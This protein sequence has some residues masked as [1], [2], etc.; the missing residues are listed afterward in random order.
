MLVYGEKVFFIKG[1]EEKVLEMLA[2]APQAPLKPGRRGWLLFYLGVCSGLAGGPSPWECGG[3]GADR[4][5]GALALP[6]WTRLVPSPLCP[7]LSL[8]SEEWRSGAPRTRPWLCC[9]WRSSHLA[10]GEPGR[11]CTLLPSP[12]SGSASP[13]ALGDHCVRP[14]AAFCWHSAGAHCLPEVPFSMG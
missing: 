5:E 13:R 9:G 2:E 11:R 6:H 10:L 7:G 3:R 8:S 4:V 14:P 1:T 12:R